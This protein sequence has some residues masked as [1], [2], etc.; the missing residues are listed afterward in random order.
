MKQAYSCIA[1]CCLFLW[2]T[3]C[4]EQVIDEGILPLTIPATTDA[5]GGNWRTVV[6]KSAAAIAVLQPADVTSAA[7]QAELTAV[8]NGIN[9]VSPE[10]SLALSYWAVGGVLRWNQIA[11]QLMSKYN[12]G[13]GYDNVLG[14]IATGDTINP[15]ANSPNAARMFAM[16]SV[17]QYD[18]LVVTWRAKYQYNRPSLTQQGINARIPVLDVPSYPSEDAAIAETSRQLLTYFFP[19]EAAWLKARAD[20]HKQSRISAG[21]NVPSDIK[22]G[23]DLAAAVA[24]S[25]ITRA[26]T[27]RLGAGTNSSWESMRTKAPYDVKWKSLEIP[28]RSPVLPSAGN[29]KTWFDSTAV[30]ATAPGP[31]PLTTSPEFQKA[32]A[33]VRDIAGARTREQYRIAAYWADGIGTFTLPG[34]WN[35]ITEAFIQEARQNELRAARTYALLNR[36][37]QDGAA[38]NW[39]TKYTY[40]VPRPSQLDP[41]IKTATSIPNYPGYTS[42]YATFSSAAATVLTYLFP[43]QA[44]SVS[45]QAAEAVV[46]QLYG[47]IHYRFD[48]EAG[49]TS[50]TRV[51]QI[52]VD[53]AK[54]DGA[55]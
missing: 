2:L 17:A 37:I 8:K 33:E 21:A 55:K 34:H 44:T 27:D 41:T 25:V 30:F 39:R 23:E 28:A 1:L 52:A 9:G 3:A 15:F 43:D 6:L 54:A 22:A 4:K 12:V 14:Q 10:Q 40:F 53:W 16:L 47:G 19:A 50:G 7:Y 31:P 46:S 51:G 24:A 48:N 5:D 38:V 13:P 49:A 32:L 35:F 20:E 36:A 26:Q 11:R 18:A 42:E 45:A 29:L